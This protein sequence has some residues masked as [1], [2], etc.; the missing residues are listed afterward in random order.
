MKLLLR[1]IFALAVLGI[2]NRLVASENAVIVVNA[3]SASSKLIANHYI[4]WR[5]IPAV[6]VVYLSGIPQREVITI[7]E[8]RN[9]I[10]KPLVTTIAQR[11]ISSSIDYILYSSDFPTI[12]NA[13]SDRNLLMQAN[14]QNAKVAANSKILNPFI[15]INAGTYFLDRVLRND[16]SYL[17]MSSNT[18]ARPEL[19]TLLLNPFAGEDREKFEQALSSIRKEKYEDAIEQLTALAQQ[20]PLQLAVLYWLART[21]AW[22]E[23]AANTIAWLK[24]CVAVGWCYREYTSRDSAFVKIKED[25]NFQALLELIPDLPGRYG[26][27]LSFRNNYLWGQNGMINSKENQGNRYILSTVLA[28]NRNKGNSELETLDYLKTSVKADGSHPG[29]T[30]YFTKT[31]DVRTRT[32]DRGI[33]EAVEEL[34]ALGFQSKVI[35]QKIPTGK[36][37]IIGLTIGTRD[38]KWPRDNEI[39]PGAICENLTS[40]GGRLLPGTKQTKL[41][42]FLRFGAAGS[43]G[44]VIEPFAIQA[45]FPHPRVHV[46]YVKGCTLAESFYQSV[47]GPFQLLIVGDGLCQPWADIPSVAITGDLKNDK[48]LSGKTSFAVQSVQLDKPVRLIELYVDGRLFR[49]INGWQT[50]QIELDTTTMPDGFHEFRFV[51]VASGTIQTRGSKTIP[52]VVNNHGKS[53]ELTTNNQAAK[54]DQKLTFEV[55][56]AGAQEIKLMHNSRVLASKKSDSAKFEVAAYKLGRGPV[57]ISG[58]AS[59]ENQVVLSKPLHLNIEGEILSSI[60]VLKSPPKKPSKRKQLPKPKQ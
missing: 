31:Q 28:V 23:D 5:N 17:S 40:F 16:P 24:R 1:L 26:P 39:I 9:K 32:R 29:G 15:S 14:N 8:F 27:T 30:F 38:F 48:P 33:D 11:K 47:V 55:S 57:T 49:R 59:F 21:Y 58:L 10:L 19:N 45:K 44:T 52:V 2:T 6:N 3:Q 43:S 46:H 7:G 56:A 13:K 50:G 20:H 37:D 51:G 41:S 4:A 18:Y 12:I 22:N 53:V 60:P 25:E 34:T 54:I 36:R 35:N 42:E